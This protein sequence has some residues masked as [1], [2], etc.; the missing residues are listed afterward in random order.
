MTVNGCDFTVTYT[1]S[2]QKGR[3]LIASFGLYERANGLDASFDLSN[4]AGQNGSGGSV[5]HTFQ[6]T[7]N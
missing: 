6:L 2:G 4:V 3:N 7:P 1:W 5:S